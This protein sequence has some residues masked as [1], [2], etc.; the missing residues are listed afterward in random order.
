MASAWHLLTFLVIGSPYFATFIVEVSVPSATAGLGVIPKDLDLY[1]NSKILALEKRVGTSSEMVHSSLG[2]QVSG[3]LLRPMECLQLYRTRT[4]VP[5]LIDKESCN[6]TQR[7][8]AIGSLGIKSYSESPNS[9][10]RL[11]ILG[12]FGSLPRSLRHCQEG[13]N[14]RRSSNR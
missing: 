11:Q 1:S 6:K 8:P 3:P 4:I 9:S 2:Y 13:D 10:S 14:K 12:F 5:N 7:I